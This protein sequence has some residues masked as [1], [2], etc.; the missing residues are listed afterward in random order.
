MFSSR[1]LNPK[2]SSNKYSNTTARSHDA[3]LSTCI[4]EGL[5]DVASVISH[6]GNI[7][8]PRNLWFLVR[9]AGYGPEADSELPWS[10][11]RINILLHR[12]LLA[13]NLGYL[14]PLEYR[15]NYRELV[16]QQQQQQQMPSAQHI[17]SDA[18][19]SSAA[20]HPDHLLSDQNEPSLDMQLLA[21]SPVVSASINPAHNECGRSS[22]F[23]CSSDVTF[24][25][26]KPD[27]VGVSPPNLPEQGILS[28]SSCSS[29][30]H[31]VTSSDP[32]IVQ[33]G[34]AENNSIGSL[35]T[36]FALE[37]DEK[38]SATTESSGSSAAVVSQI[39]TPTTLHLQP[40]TR[41]DRVAVEQ[42]ADTAPVE[43][44]RD[45]KKRPL[46]DVMIK[47]ADKYKTNKRV[48]VS[49]GNESN[50]GS[51]GTDGD[52]EGVKYSRGNHKRSRKMTRRHK[53]SSSADGANKRRK[54]SVQRSLADISTAF[55]KAGVKRSAPFEV[56]SD[57]SDTNMF[58][59]VH[60]GKFKLRVSGAKH[61]LVSS[62]LFLLLENILCCKYFTGQNLPTERPNIK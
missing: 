19:D 38:R 20:L 49:G 27:G 54:E 24:L 14:I 48:K 59:A 35:T 41:E 3:P 56:Q 5:Y 60:N 50:G 2:S 26:V 39:S 58:S 22:R 11:L 46:A 21:E 37:S 25:G 29:G 51:D 4:D 7:K 10:E 53:Q 12:Y 36:A 61:K 8:K 33:I 17:M 13:H 30:A 47:Q 43:V 57:D 42:Q 31:E 1:S 18:R 55:L 9:W 52:D 45:V 15:E 44:S 28:D 34:V 62:L 16:A 40:W 6:R 23:H 32:P